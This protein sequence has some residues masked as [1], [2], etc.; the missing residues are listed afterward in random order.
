M[1]RLLMITVMLALTGVVSL[2]QS[3]RDS[4]EGRAELIA[5]PLDKQLDRYYLMQYGYDENMFPKYIMDEAMRKRI[6]V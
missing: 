3:V 5:L 2:A 6:K 4:A 1:K